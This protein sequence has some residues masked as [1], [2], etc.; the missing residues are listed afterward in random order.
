MEGVLP[1]IIPFLSA[2]NRVLT[3]MS[4]SICH[5]ALNIFNRQTSLYYTAL[6]M[7]RMLC[8]SQ[9]SCQTCVTKQTKQSSGQ[10]TMTNRALLWKVKIIM[11]LK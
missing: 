8:L 7:S 10:Q 4:I 11:V 9:Y 2:V 3:A 1:S 6:A 5:S